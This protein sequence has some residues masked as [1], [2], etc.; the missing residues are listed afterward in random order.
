MPN[1]HKELTS[2]SRWALAS[3]S[4]S[5]LMPSLDTSIANVGLPSLVRAFD[6][7]FQGVQWVVLAYL[8]AITSLIVGAGRVGDIVS[9]RRLLLLGVAAFTAASLLCGIAPSLPLLIAARAAQGLGAAMM[10]AMTLALV[11]E[12][13]PPSQT[14]SA[15]GL[16]GTMSAIGTTL[17]PSLGGVLIAAIGWRSIFLIN[18]P[19]GV[20]NYLLVR[21][22]VPIS[23]NARTTRVRFDIA[24][25]GV[26][27][28]TLAAYALAM[29]LG[30]TSFGPLN[31]ALLIAAALGVA[32]FVVIERKVASPLVQP[33][34]LRERALSTGLAA[35]SLVSTVMMSTLVVGPF[36][37]S[38]GLGL[39]TA[40][41]GLTMSIGPLTS[42]LAGVPAGRLVD[43]AGAWRMSFVGLAGMVIG[44]LALVSM[45]NTLGVI[46]YAGP[47]MIVTA[48][49]ALFQAANNTGL[50]KDVIPERRGV[51]S[52]MLSLSRNLGLITGA[53]VM[54]AVFVYSVGTTAIPSASPNSVATGMRVT[55]GV[56]AA[57]I[58]LA[59]ALVATRPSAPRREHTAAAIGARDLHPSAGARAGTQ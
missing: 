2:A 12:A 35:S 41:V 36:Y 37:L 13:I 14:G 52:G 40:A 32:L 26:L 29:T 19:L 30:R 58:G 54:G 49:Y 17:G 46:G 33:A 24:G 8:L 7:S 59:L 28:A 18:V 45:P 38:R 11:G 51:I 5:I 25:T 55:F 48:S 15:M 22:H 6:T 27:A 56:A 39:G 9:R 47:I 20:L 23:R 1:A 44:L 16:L 42:A 3:L 50:M 4:L 53:A 43:R 34:L 10:L 31:A 21:R 57:V